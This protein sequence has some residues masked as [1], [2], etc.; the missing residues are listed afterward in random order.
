MKKPRQKILALLSLKPLFTLLT[1]A[2]TCTHHMSRSW[3]SCKEEEGEEGEEGSGSHS[4]YL[5]PPLGH[6]P[7]TNSD[8]ESETKL[9]GIN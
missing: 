5:L 9:S 7:L 6:H 3:F 2:T 1:Y 4:S 8:E